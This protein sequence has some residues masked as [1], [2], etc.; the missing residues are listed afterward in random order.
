M[1]LPNP[2]SDSMMVGGGQDNVITGLKVATTVSLGY[3]AGADLYI[4]MAVN[5]ALAAQKDSLAAGKVRMASLVDMTT[6]C[7]S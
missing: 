5:P 4:D 2:R 7:I 1:L 6:Y 3:F